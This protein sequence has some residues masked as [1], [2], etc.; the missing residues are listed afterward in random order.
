M[1][2]ENNPLFGSGDLCGILGILLIACSR[3]GTC[4]RRD[5]GCIRNQTLQ[6]ST[7]VRRLPRMVGVSGCHLLGSFYK[8]HCSFPSWPALTPTLGAAFLIIS[9]S[10]VSRFGPAPLLGRIFPQFLGRIS[11]SLYLWH[12]PL[13]VL[14]LAIKSIPLNIYERVGLALLVIPFAY[15]TQRWIG[16]PFRCG[17]FIGTLPHKNLLTAVAMAQVIAGV[18][19]GTDYLVTTNAHH[20]TAKM[21]AEQK[22]A[23]VDALL[24]PLVKTTKSANSRHG[25]EYNH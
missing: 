24:N 10:R 21:T 16:D 4:T 5:P 11:Y 18:S 9:G 13:P 3:V 12:W 15:A 1:N 17:K 8:R 14:P 23:E 2:L 22:A 20:N 19:L 7:G 6:N 25:L